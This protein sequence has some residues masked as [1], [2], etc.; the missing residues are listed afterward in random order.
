M[1]APPDGDDPRE[2]LEEQE[3]LWRITLGPLIWTA[4]FLLSY[5]AAAVVCAKLPGPDAL[6][7]LRVALGLLTILALGLTVWVGARAWREW[8]VL[9]DRDYENSQGDAEDRHQFLNHAALLLAIVSFVGIVFVS[10]PIVFA[11]TC[12]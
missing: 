10:L 8:D 11:G 3:S 1:A 4:H 5:G 7:A 9:G 6:L 2:F 12:R